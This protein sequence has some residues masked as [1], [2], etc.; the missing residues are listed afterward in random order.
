MLLWLCFL[1]LWFGAYLFQSQIARFE[2]CAFIRWQEGQK[3][4]AEQIQQL[5]AEQE[6]SFVLWNTKVQESLKTAQGT[7]TVETMEYLGDMAQMHAGRFLEGGWPGDEKGG[8]V[9]LSLI[10]I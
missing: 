10:H 7:A 4:S 6:L 1:F 8:V 2:G 9:T 5:L 3:V